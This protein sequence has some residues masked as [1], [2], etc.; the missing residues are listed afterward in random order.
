[1]RPAHNPML[2]LGSMTPFTLATLRHIILEGGDLAEALIGRLTKHYSLEKIVKIITSPPVY[3]NLLPSEGS[4]KFNYKIKPEFNKFSA[5]PTYY[6]SVLRNSGISDTEKF[7]AISETIIKK[8]RPEISYWGQ[9][10]ILIDDIKCYIDGGNLEVLPGIFKDFD[11]F[12]TKFK[13]VQKYL[14]DNGFSPSSLVQIES[15]GGCHLNFDLKCITRFGPNF[16]SKFINNYKQLMIN[17]PGVIWAF[18]PPNDNVSSN[19]KFYLDCNDYNKGD[20]FTV[21]NFEGHSVKTWRELSYIEI[22]HFMMPRTYGE[23]KMHYDFCRAILRYVFKI[24]NS[25]IVLP[26]KEPKLKLYTYARAVRETKE[27]CNL[28]DFDFSLFSE[29][30]KF[31]MLK[32][33]FSY[34]DSYKV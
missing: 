31:G 15:E 17:N 6:P 13:E 5:E 14:L 12:Y 23:F 10:V 16:T 24:T 18:I 20:F 21:R 27:L 3:T 22:R 7:N 26:E 8:F 1:M 33:R 19:I 11:S 32:T 2:P 25:N 29:F 34:G 9:K 4:R 30:G 28:I